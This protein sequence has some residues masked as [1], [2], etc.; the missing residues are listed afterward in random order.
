MLIDRAANRAPWLRP[1]RAAALAAV[2][3][4]AAC[5][6]S[7][8]PTPTSGPW[9]TVSA[10][11]YFTCG[12][13][14]SGT[15]YCWGLNFA[16]ELGEGATD[17]FPADYVATPQAVVG[18]LQFAGI[19]ASALYACGLT[20]DGAA[21]CWGENDYGQMGDG[22]VD[23]V[24]AATHPGPAPVAGGFT[25]TNLAPGPTHTCGV[26]SAGISLCWGSGS[27]GELADG[28]TMG[29][30]P[31]PA[32]IGSPLQLASMAVGYH[33]TCGLT[34]DGSAYCWGGDE[35][36]VLGT[37]LVLSS[38]VP[39]AVHGGLAFTTLAAG[40][41]HTCGLTSSGAAYCWGDDRYGQLGVAGVQFLSTAPAAVWGG[42]AFKSLT[43]GR[44]HTCGLTRAGVAYCWGLN[45][46]GQLGDG[47][48]ENRP[49]P[50]LVN[51]GL[52][53]ASIGAGEEHTCGVTPGGV[54]Y[55]WG[56]NSY[57]QLG[58]GSADP[59]AHPAPQAVGGGFT[60]AELDRR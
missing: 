4:L 49:V 27:Y 10:G 3:C 46:R 30:R 11:S 25:F 5:R 50:V 56:D 33:H 54:A 39:V 22:T 13:T 53:F 20:R 35:W 47:S 26:T 59:V 21:Y 32:P 2:C 48:T 28:D 23:S 42:Y 38:P 55:C 31:T 29:T 8:A 57:G 12:L 24:G 17:S 1:A 15:A 6:E 40:E 52:T 58:T 9:M 60:A 51:G 36:G 7:T 43:A 41:L 19:S 14:R 45:D 34:G 16:G 44:N 37:G 18:G